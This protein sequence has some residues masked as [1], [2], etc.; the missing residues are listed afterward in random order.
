M[1]FICLLSR[2]EKKKSWILFYFVIRYTTFWP[3]EWDLDWAR[4]LTVGWNFFPLFSAEFVE[5]EGLPE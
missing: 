5:G 1:L 2:K 4:L 3:Q